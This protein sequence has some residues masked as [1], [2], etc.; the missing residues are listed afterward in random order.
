M[1]ISAVGK[2]YR[3]IGLVGSARWWGGVDKFN[4]MFKINKY[5]F[6]LEQQSEQKLNLPCVL[7][8]RKLHTRIHTYTSV[9]QLKIHKMCLKIRKTSP[10]DRK[11]EEI[12][13]FKYK[14]SVWLIGS[15]N[16]T[17]ELKIPQRLVRNKNRAG[18]LHCSLGFG[19]ERE[20]AIRKCELGLCLHR[21]TIKYINYS[22]NLER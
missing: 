19:E 8:H 5:K 21:I 18:G 2:K 6:Y 13:S 14:V 17:Q 7:N 4:L 16:L 11:R 1:V 3:I 22:L 12:H 10:Q 15:K 20:V 9:H